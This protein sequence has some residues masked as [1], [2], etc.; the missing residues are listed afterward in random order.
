MTE[1]EAV[2]SVAP[3]YSYNPITGDITRKKTGR[4]IG[5]RNK[6]RNYICFS[7]DGRIIYAHRIAWWYMTGALPKN[8]IDHIN[9]NTKD[10]RFINLREAT[11]RE[12]NI[13]LPIHRDGRLP[14]ALWEEKRQRYRPRIRI[15][16]SYHRLGN[17][18]TAEEANAAYM[19]AFEMAEAK[20]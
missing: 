2:E 4:I 10:N 7:F 3:L 13:N 17:Y 14:G 11:R 9:G 15:N 6:S 16:G 1:I 8:E 5:S 20:T 19:K 12:N 18:K